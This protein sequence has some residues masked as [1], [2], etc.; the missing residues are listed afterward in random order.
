MSTEFNLQNLIIC[1]L[2]CLYVLFATIKS[3][4]ALRLRAWTSGYFYIQL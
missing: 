3:E 4:L 2:R 1:E